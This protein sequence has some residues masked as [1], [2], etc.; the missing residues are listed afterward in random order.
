MKPIAFIGLGIMGS[1][2]CRRLLDAGFRVTVFNRTRAHA[3]GVLAHGATWADSAAAA[4]RQAEVVI[5][6]LAD[7][8]SVQAVALG[9]DGVLAGSA[10]GALYIDMTT[11]DPATPQRLLQACAERGIDFLEAPVTGSKPAAAAGELVLMVG[12]DPTVLNRALPVL[13]PLS[14]KIVHM[15]AVGAGARMKLANNLIIA[16]AVQA[17]SEG[18]VLGL[19]LGLPADRMAEVLTSGGLA[20]P[21]L[22][23]KTDAI[24]R[25]AYEPQ[26][27]VKHMA[28]DLRLALD[29]ASTAQVSLPAT[30]VVHA[31]YTAARAHGYADEDFAAVAKII[32]SL[33]GT[34]DGASA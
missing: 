30:A 3:D 33:S 15:G 19:R 22:R 13:Q 29:E 11:V 26:F 28:K 10:R 4:A 6:M 8:A 34:A 9:P 32:E 17:L 5:T 27:S 2:I 14:K 18:L 7:P 20:S 1:R 12:G 31:L 25:R 23:I 24:L 16:G 21:L